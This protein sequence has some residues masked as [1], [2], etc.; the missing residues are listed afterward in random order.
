MLSLANDPKWLTL[1]QRLHSVADVPGFFAAMKSIVN[2][3]TPRR[4]TL[5]HRDKALLQ[6]LCLHVGVTARKL[7]ASEHDTQQL[8]AQ[9]KTEEARALLSRLTTAE[10]DIVQLVRAGC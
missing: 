10:R 8:A 9:L 1:L 4:H 7:S 2:E 6:V 5:T 3:A